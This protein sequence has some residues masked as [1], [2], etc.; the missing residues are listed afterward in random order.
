MKIMISGGTGLIGQQ[1]VAELLKKGHEVWVLSST[2]TEN[3]NLP[4]AYLI[5]WDGSSLGKW[6]EYVDQMDV[7]INLAGANI[8]S[9]R[10]TIKRKR[11]I[12][13]SR[14]KAGKI[15]TEAIKKSNNQTKVFIQASAIGF[16][17]K[18][19]HEILNEQ[20]SGCSDFMGGICK[21]WEASSL[22][23]ESLGIRRIII[24]TGIVLSKKDGILNRMMLPFKFFIGGPIGNGNQI[25]SWIHIDDEVSAIQFLLENENA[26][27]V[28]NLTAP[29]PA[30][31]SGIGKKL[32]KIMNRPYWIP[33]PAIFLRFFLGEMSS[34]VLDGQNIFP[35]RLLEAGYSFKFEK[36]DD[37]LTDLLV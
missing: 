28:F 6:S 8:G 15:L 1:L 36:I 34:L 5:G 32:A 21:D 2:R 33:A 23:V 18:N 7:I 37:A 13:E 24:R 10:W 27:G 16:Y 26:K 31:N 12:V 9:K 19:R 35:Q 17:D 30:S 22:E 25:L 11:L 3:H 20:N 4:G 29:Y 14:V